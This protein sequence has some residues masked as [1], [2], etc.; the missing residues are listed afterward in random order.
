MS[1]RTAQYEST[2]IAGQ[3]AFRRRSLAWAWI[4]EHHPE[5]AKDIASKAAAEFPYQPRKWEV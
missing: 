4:V 3:R 5:V 1:Q 2:K